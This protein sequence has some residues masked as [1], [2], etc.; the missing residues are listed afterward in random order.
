MLHTPI[1]GY[2][3]SLISVIFGLYA[4]DSLHIQR[5]VIDQIILKTDGQIPESLSELFE[6]VSRQFLYFGLIN[7]TLANAKTFDPIQSRLSQV[8][9]AG[10]EFTQVSDV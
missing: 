3:I 10:S 5:E 8:R 7:G 4:D 9:T 2:W 1:P 6:F